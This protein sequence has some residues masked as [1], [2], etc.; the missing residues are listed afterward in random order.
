VAQTTF[1]EENA[2][3]YVCLCEDDCK[4]GELRATRSRG[5]LDS[6]REKS[7]GMEYGSDCSV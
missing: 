6:W 3:Q 2:M 7:G 1:E 4:T 5:I